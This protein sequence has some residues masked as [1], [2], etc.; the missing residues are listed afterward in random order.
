MHQRKS[1]ESRV[2]RMPKGFKLVSMANEERPSHVHHHYQQTN[3]KKQESY[4]TFKPILCV[5]HYFYP[6]FTDTSRGLE[7]EYMPHHLIHAQTTICVKHPVSICMLVNTI[8]CCLNAIKLN[9]I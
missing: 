5:K 6:H 4:S 2:Q 9:V 7:W 3:K 8:P 1:R